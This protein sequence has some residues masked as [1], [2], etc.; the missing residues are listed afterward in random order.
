MP[1]SVSFRPRAATRCCNAFHQDGN[2]CPF[3]AMSSSLPSETCGFMTCEA[4]LASPTRARCRVVPVVVPRRR[5]LL[6]RCLSP[7]CWWGLV[8][9]SPPAWS[10]A[11]VPGARLL[12]T[13]SAGFTVLQGTPCT[14]CRPRMYTQFF[15]DLAA[16]RGLHYCNI[17]MQHL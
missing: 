16:S 8:R 14:H 1:G 4:S 3:P 12:C 6:Q 10:A 15:C 7:Q 9:R 13:A 2:E 17:F 5:L 11:A